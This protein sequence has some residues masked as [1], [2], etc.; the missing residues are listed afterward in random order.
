M[1]KF[2]TTRLFASI[3]LI[4]ILLSL[5]LAA[6]Q[7]GPAQASVRTVTLKI[8][9]RATSGISIY[10][11]GTYRYYLQ[12][13]GKSTQSFTINQG[14]YNYTIK[15]CGMTAKSKVNLSGDTLMI[16]P[17]CGGN[18]RSIPKVGSKINLGAVLKVVPVTVSSK[19]D[20][21]TYVVLTGP[22]TYVFTLGPGQN[23]DVTIA[24][25]TFNVRYYACGVFINREFTANKNS[26]LYL[27][28]P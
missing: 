22:S 1:N 2:T 11:E 21:K 20:Y 3:S 28:C 24:K 13:A 12:I 15:G 27:R 25:G 6:V 4:A 19:L 10:L 5:F 9:N 26:T 17:V 7:V 18:V 16:N 23:L 14:S 8:D